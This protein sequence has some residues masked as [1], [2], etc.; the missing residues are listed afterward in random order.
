MGAPCGLQFQVSDRNGLGM[1]G[2]GMA[3]RLL[4]PLEALPAGLVPSRRL[5][6]WFFCMHESR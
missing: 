6:A 4:P 2:R 1:K 5:A 3:A